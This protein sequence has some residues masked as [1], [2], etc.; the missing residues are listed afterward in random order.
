MRGHRVSIRILRILAVAVP[1]I[2]VG[3]LIFTVRSSQAPTAGR[4]EER[5]ES[6]GGIARLVREDR[7]APTFELP[8]VEGERTISLASLS[9]RVV[10]LDFWASWCPSCREEAPTM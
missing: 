2:A 1:L 8:T 4:P 6:G 5:G 9:G 3:V 7:P 10:L